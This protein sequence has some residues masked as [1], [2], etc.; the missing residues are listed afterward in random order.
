MKQA[1]NSIIHKM[2][3]K[4]GSEN[5]S[6]YEW[7][8]ARLDTKEMGLVD[9]LKGLAGGFAE[10]A[11]AKV[12]VKRQRPLERKISK[13]PGIG[14]KAPTT[15][16]FTKRQNASLAQRIEILDWHHAQAKPSHSKTA[17]HFGEKLI[18]LQ[19]SAPR[20]ISLGVEVGL[21]VNVR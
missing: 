18:H 12:S 5:A 6:D 11:A 3:A 9:K 19:M 8:L 14:K 21:V 13:N 1:Q 2:L 7:G 15:P 20:Y 10:K 16:V 17:A 4:F